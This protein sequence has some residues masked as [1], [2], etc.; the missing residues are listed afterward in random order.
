MG[1]RVHGARGEA[2][3]LRGPRGNKSDGWV[4]LSPSEEGRGERGSALAVSL[5]TK[6]GRRVFCNFVEKLLGTEA[7]PPVG[8]GSGVGVLVPREDPGG[9]P[10]MPRDGRGAA[11]REH[12]VGG[13]ALERPGGSTHRVSPPV[14]WLGRPRLRRWTF[15]SPRL[16]P[17]AL[18]GPEP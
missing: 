13:Q 5:F 14:T 8:D 16:C 17:A 1:T 10:E 11:C 3:A 12:G 6:K 4:L 2:P 18:A 7:S 15:S 9:F